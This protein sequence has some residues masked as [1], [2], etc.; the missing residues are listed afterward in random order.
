VAIY[1]LGLDRRDVVVLG[2]INMDLVV[3]APRLPLAGETLRGTRFTIS[4]GG[5]GAN[6]AVA[7]ARQG[8]SVRMIGSVGDD[9]F[10]RRL[11]EALAEEGIDAARVGTDPGAPTGVASIVVTGSG[12]NHI[13]TVGGANHRVG[14]RELHLL[15]EVLPD[16]SMLLVQLEIGAAVVA[17]AVRR[18]R[19]RGVAVLLD[20]AP[21]AALP[22]E[23][24]GDVDWITPNAH[25]TEALTGVAP[26]TRG[27]AQRAGEILRGRGVDH[28]AITL[29][30]EGCF[31]TG[32]EGSFAVA[33]PRVAVVDTTAVGDAF[34]GAL[35]AALDGGED[36]GSSLE[37]A[38]CAGALAATRRGAQPSLPAAAEVEA[39]LAKR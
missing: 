20:P 8:A 14:T 13:V 18:A 15:D 21:V 36:V 5:K 9:D 17:A 33:A 7:A 12:E 30:A 27:D 23:I 22:E 11:T 25:E 35:A 16:A 19:A 6:Q 10:G 3:E 1:D 26:L 24:Y 32:T 31:Y 38:C 34:A 37:R 2:S 39:L 28:V 29:G 4:P